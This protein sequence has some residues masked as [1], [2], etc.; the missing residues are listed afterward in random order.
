MT[1]VASTP[2]PITAGPIS[3]R[4]SPTP[5]TA[6]AAASVIKDG[7]FCGIE[8]ACTRHNSELIARE[9]VRPL[10]DNGCATMPIPTSRTG[11]TPV[12]PRANQAVA[13]GPGPLWPLG[14]ACRPTSAKKALSAAP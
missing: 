6:R 9:S 5:A 8:S 11:C 10:A 3:Y 12:E 14:H 1:T 7:R 2:A 13:H 4:W